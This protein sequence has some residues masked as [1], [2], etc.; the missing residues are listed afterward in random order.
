MLAAAYVL[1]LDD[2]AAEAGVPRAQLRDR[3]DE[4]LAAPLDSAPAG[5]PDS[6][7][8]VIQRALGLPV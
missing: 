4:E 7:E 5:E 8:T 6:A 1:W 3:F 2:L